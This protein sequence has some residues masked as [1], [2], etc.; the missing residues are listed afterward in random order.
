MDQVILP[1]AGRLEEGEGLRWFLVLWVSHP[2]PMV[3]KCFLHIE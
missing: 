2:C 3:V 1:G